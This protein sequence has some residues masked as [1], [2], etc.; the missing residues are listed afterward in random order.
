MS[1]SL[2]M[3]LLFDLLT[4]VRAI[5]VTAEPKATEP[6]YALTVRDHSETPIHSS[7][8]TTNCTVSPGVV[9]NTN[10]LENQLG[11]NTNRNWE[12]D[13]CSLDGYSSMRYQVGKLF[14]AMNK[15]WHTDGAGWITSLSIDEGSAHEVYWGIFSTTLRETK[16]ASLALQAIFTLYT[17]NFDYDQLECFTLF[18]GK[19]RT[20]TTNSTIQA[21]HEVII[22]T[23]KWELFVVWG[24]I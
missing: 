15:Q 14:W 11:V 3:T 24:L 13:I 9:V 20:F 2:A 6:E 5:D 18:A 22:P 4:R 8:C 7:N 19:Y 12:R 16:T 21:I 1:S 23:K 17:S 10:A